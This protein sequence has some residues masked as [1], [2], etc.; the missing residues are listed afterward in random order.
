MKNYKDFPRNDKDPQCGKLRI[1][2]FNPKL[3]PV[4]IEI[5][6]MPGKRPVKDSKCVVVKK[7]EIKKFLD[8]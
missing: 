1:I 6:F 2:K 3:E 5:C 8:L 7:S 4:L